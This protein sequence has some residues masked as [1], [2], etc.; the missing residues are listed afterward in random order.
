M[1]RNSS[2][3]S[4]QKDEFE[5]HGVRLGSRDQRL[6]GQKTVRVSVVAEMITTITSCYI[7]HGKARKDQPIFGNLSD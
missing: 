5:R 6:S 4:S 3:F 2:R 1:L 7:S